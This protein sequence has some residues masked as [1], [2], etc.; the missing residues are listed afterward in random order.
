MNKKYP[1]FSVLITVYSKENPMHFDEALSSIEQQTI[2]PDEIVLVKD[3][4]LT[5]ELDEVVYNHQCKYPEKYVIQSLNVRCGQGIAL[6]KG[7]ELV[8]NEWIARMDSDDFSE[9]D[10]F[11]KQLQVIVDAPT[12]CVVGG[13]VLEFSGNPNNTVGRRVVPESYEEIV[14]YARYRNPINHSTSMIKKTALLDVG[15][16]RSV[17]KMEDY[18]LWA[19]FII[20]GYKMVNIQK[21]LVRMRVSDGMYKR[22]GGWRFLITYIRMKRKWRKQGLGNIFTEIVSDI[23]MTISVFMPSSLRKIMYKK[24]LH[25]Y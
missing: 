21:N 23:I 5:P 4:K 18:D 15:N 6:R 22:R 8:T 1:G 3:G 11:E 14:K 13:N 9:V 20:A 12:I 7:V 25:K 2:E 17:E 10:R 16:Y 19:R 24:L